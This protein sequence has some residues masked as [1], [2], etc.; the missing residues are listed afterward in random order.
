[1]ISLSASKPTIDSTRRRLDIFSNKLVSLVKRAPI[2]RHGLDT[3]QRQSTLSLTYTEMAFATE[4]SRT[5]TSS[6]MMFFRCV[7]CSFLSWERPKSM[8]FHQVK[9]I[10]F[11]SAVLYDARM[12]P[13]FYE[14]F[15]GTRNFAASGEPRFDFCS[16]TSHT[17]DPCTKRN[18]ARS[19]ISGC[20]S[21]SMVFG[22]VT[23][24][25]AHGGSSF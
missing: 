3:H 19:A 25:T 20:T 18:L 9:L 7:A 17:E 16:L 21:R 4:I 24:D 1:M 15:F 11:G 13:P 22:C 8:A 12:N 10:D 5:K 6:S 14:L 2:S 23:R